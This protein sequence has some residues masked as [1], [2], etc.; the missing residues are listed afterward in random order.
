MVLGADYGYDNENYYFPQ[1]GITYSNSDYFNDIHGVAENFV[2]ELQKKTANTQRQALLEETRE[3]LRWAKQRNALEALKKNFENLIKEFSNETAVSPVSKK[4]Y[5]DGGY[6]NYAQ[7]YIDLK[8]EST[9]ENGQMIVHTGDNYALNVTGRCLAVTTYTA[10]EY[11][12]DGDYDGKTVQIQVTDGAHEEATNNTF[13][14]YYNLAHNALDR[15]I[16]GTSTDAAG[17]KA[18]LTRVL[19]P[20]NDYTNGYLYKYTYDKLLRKVFSESYSYYS[21]YQV[22]RVGEAMFS[23][24]SDRLAK[25]RIRDLLDSITTTS[26]SLKTLAQAKKNALMTATT[27]YLTELE[28]ILADWADTTMGS[29][30]AQITELLT[31][32]KS[33][34]K[35]LSDLVSGLD[36]TPG[37]SSPTTDPAQLRAAAST[38]YTDVYA[39][40][41]FFDSVKNTEVDKT[42]VLQKSE[43]GGSITNSYG[44]YEKDN[45]YILGKGDMRGFRDIFESVMYDL[46]K[47][48]TVVNSGL[49]GAMDQFEYS[50]YLSPAE[51]KAAEEE[52]VK[53]FD[54]LLAVNWEGRDSGHRIYSAYELRRIRQQHFI[55]SDFVYDYHSVS[56]YSSKWASG[57]Y[58]DKDNGIYNNVLPFN[59]QGDAT[60][61][62]PYLFIKGRGIMNASTGKESD[63]KATGVL[64][65]Y[66]DW[67]T[68]DMIAEDQSNHA[69]HTVSEATDVA[70]EAKEAIAEII[71]LSATDSGM[72]TSSSGMGS[73]KTQV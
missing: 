50:M 65:H 41:S 23:Y 72:W 13:M 69:Y 10:L 3:K 39:L 70:A 31:T 57:S 20:D 35:A 58:V 71:E 37:T 67:L 8:S 32:A 18:L 2:T 26:S 42:V 66:G 1:K 68:S 11:I 28:N 52:C 7:V 36:Y 44:Y 30:T 43:S 54:L 34:V 14:Y 33:S 73:Y 56:A 62:Y 46:D 16:G 53:N 17:D 4:P 64:F 19:G 40:Y 9:K 15:L 61:Y 29:Y 27:K 24:Y 63:D 5:R 12:Y 47:T 45:G 22:D 21:Y 49:D 59:E 6:G 60:K 38:A 55:N 51:V 48:V 25:R